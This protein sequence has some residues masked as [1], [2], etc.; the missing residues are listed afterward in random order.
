MK[1]IKPPARLAAEIREQLAQR[2]IRSGAA[3]ARAAGMGQPQVHRNLFGRPKRVTRTLLPL[4]KYAGV[5]AYE[6]TNDPRESQVLM[7]ALAIVWDGTDSHA[8]RLA[9]LLL[10]HRQ[11]RV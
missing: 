10:A 8:R 2:G 6:G 3:I 1:R 7:E 9:K 4:C 5:E 11:A